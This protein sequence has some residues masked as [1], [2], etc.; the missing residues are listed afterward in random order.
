MNPFLKGLIPGPIKKAGKQFILKSGHKGIK[1]RLSTSI[2]DNLVYPNFCLR[3]SMNL[4]VFSN[5]RRNIIYKEV[6]EHVSFEI[7]EAYLDEIHRNNSH[8]IK[9]IERFK[10]N[11][12]YGNPDLYE[13]PNIGKISPSTLR[14]IK[15]LGDLII[16]FKQLDNLNICE[17]GVGYGGQ[18]RIINCQ[19]SPTLY[20]LVDIK[21]A[22]LLS[23]RYLD[24]YILNSTVEYKTMNELTVKN[25]DLVIS[26]YAF[27][28]LPRSI[29]DVYL[30]KIILN[31][32]C[33]YITYNETTP[34]YFNSY[35]KEQLINI[36]P[37]S[38]IIEEKPLTHKGNCII[39]WGEH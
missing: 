14:Y 20:T 30:K 28:E 19:S 36:I 24:N 32:K 25:Y 27:T 38:H 12:A 26:N 37:N 39:L 18:C 6:L 3:A 7:G 8:L 23:Q 13:Y 1:P 34:E 35:K 5:F 2:S 21:P 17:I 4:R 31:S 15:V 22:L 29:Q 10:E 33:G 16:F 11:D 9:N